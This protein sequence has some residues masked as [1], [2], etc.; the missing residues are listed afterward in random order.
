MMLTALVIGTLVAA[1]GVLLWLDRSERD[2]AVQDAM[3]RAE[4][5]KIEFFRSGSYASVV[6]SL[7]LDEK[8]LF[9]PLTGRA[10]AAYEV[11][12]E[13]LIETGAGERWLKVVHEW[14]VQ[15]FAVDDGTG[16]AYVDPKGALLSIVGDHRT[17][18]GP[19]GEPDERHL[20]FIESQDARV[21]SLI[22]EDSRLRYREGVLEVGEKVAVLGRGRVS[23]DDMTV[24]APYRGR[25]RVRVDFEA[26]FRQPVYV[27]DDV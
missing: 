9:A 12:V 20:A 10:C 24:E 27:T 19:F 7:V 15:R 1:G 13:R 5:V 21:F 17:M 11:L 23:T 2:R 16:R 3:A 6:G 18:T 22:G 26:A 25:P 8:P 14:D 4:R